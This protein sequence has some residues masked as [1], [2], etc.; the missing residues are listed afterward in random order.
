MTSITIDGPA[1]AGKTTVAKALSEKLGYIYFN[2]GAVYR[3]IA[4][5][6]LVNP[7]DLTKTIK[8]KKFL[9]QINLKIINKNNVQF[10]W[11]D[12]IDITQKLSTPEMDYWSSKISQYKEVREFAVSLQRNFAYHQNIVI[13]GR[14]IGSNV[15]PN[16]KFKFYLTASVD[17]RAKR[18]RKQYLEQGG[19]YAL[20]SYEK[21]LQDII[22]RDK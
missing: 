6:Y 13:E 7:F 14:D 8:L 17:V 1:G 20:I 9:S 19:E 22:E 18:R 12:N 2:T 5:C 3:S 16:A 10:I 21:I 4:Y 11:L 15:L